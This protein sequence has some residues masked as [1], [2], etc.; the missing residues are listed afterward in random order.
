MFRHS[1]LPLVVCT[2]HFWVSSCSLQWYPLCLAWCLI[3]VA[4]PPA[5]HWLKAT[6]CLVEVA[7]TCS[8]DTQADTV[9]PQPTVHSLPNRRHRLKYCSA[10]M[11]LLQKFYFILSHVLPSNQ[12]PFLTIWK[13]IYMRA[14]TYKFI[15]TRP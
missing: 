6:V 12:S 14:Y 1:H 9:Q 15:Y 4:A 10:F 7:H 2:D 8:G 5:S 13:Y 11:L 3:P